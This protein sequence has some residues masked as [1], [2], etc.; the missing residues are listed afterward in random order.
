[1][2]AGGKGFPAA[3]PWAGEVMSPSVVLICHENDPIDSEGIAAWLASDF[4]LAGIVLLRDERGSWWRKLRREYRRVGWLRLL[5]VIFF[6]I[7]Y[8]LSRSRND[9]RWVSEQVQALCSRYPADFSSV[10]R[11]VV[12]DPNQPLVRNF[13][14]GLRP[15]FVIARCKYI[16]QPFI[17]NIPRHG[18]FA[19]HPG[20]CPLYRNAHGCFWALADRDLT[21]VGMTLLKINKG[22]DTG[23][24]YLQASYAFDEHRESHVVIQH[25]VV[26][27]NLDGIS[28]TLK[29]IS[30]DT[31]RPLAAG[32]KLSR[33]RGQPWFTAYLRWKRRARAAF[34]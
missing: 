8:L 4:S 6:R 23:P 9:R 12:A 7:F 30:M 28:R 2:V 18:S 19:L 24:V 26:L 32:D 22:I 29:A 27:E 16:L 34:A 14:S 31:A 15:D 1:M 20:N 25:R 13:I 10:P 33:N 11:L 5:D 3:L 21:R 17:F